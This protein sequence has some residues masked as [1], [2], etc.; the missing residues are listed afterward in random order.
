M[1]DRKTKAKEKTDSAAKRKPAHVVIV[2]VIYKLVEQIE[3]RPN[4]ILNIAT[5]L[6]FL[7]LFGILENMVI[8]EHALPGI[9]R[10]LTAIKRKVKSYAIIY[11]QLKDLIKILRDYLKWYKKE[12]RMDEKFEGLGA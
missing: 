4:P 10:E 1:S 9:I 5:S 3:E 7:P 2:E 12:R 6:T 8:P 11:A